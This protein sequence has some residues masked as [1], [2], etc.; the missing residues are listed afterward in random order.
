MAIHALRIDSGRCVA[1]FACEVSCEQEN[2]L[3]FG[4]SWIRISKTEE[5]LPDDKVVSRLLPRLC[6]HCEKPPCVPNCPEQA[7]LKNLNGI[8]LIKFEKCTG[9]GICV[10]SCA[11]GA[12]QVNHD[13]SVAQKCTMCAH[14]IDKGL[15]PTCA[16]HCPA[17]AITFVK[18]FRSTA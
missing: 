12:I 16:K 4:V 11:F 18:D 13:M 10:D 15:P 6:R 3:P 9:C 2:G 8:V 5:V 14:L 17:R 7:I 1:C